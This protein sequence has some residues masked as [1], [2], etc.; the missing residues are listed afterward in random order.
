MGAAG[1]GSGCVFI[2][3][4]A[5]AGLLPAG[6]GAGPDKQDAEDE[7]EGVQEAELTDEGQL[8]HDPAD[9]QDAGD[10]RCVRGP[11]MTGCLKAAA[12]D[13]RTHGSPG[14][15]TQRSSQSSGPDPAGQGRL[16]STAG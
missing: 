8:D 12:F 10:D 5:V 1:T 14:R 11:A 9:Q 15:R 2:V 7:V 6:R 16:A 3:S 4:L 13:T